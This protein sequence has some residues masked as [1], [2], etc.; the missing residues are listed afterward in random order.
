MPTSML[1]ELVPTA[2]DESFHTVCMVAASKNATWVN[3]LTR[4]MARNMGSLPSAKRSSQWS[5]W[6]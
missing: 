1:D 2:W 5:M 3:V 4:S 6:T